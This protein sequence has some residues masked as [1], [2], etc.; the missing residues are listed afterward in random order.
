MTTSPLVQTLT[1]LVHFLKYS[2]DLFSQA[3]DINQF[4][5]IPSCSVYTYWMQ[6]VHCCTFVT[7]VSYGTTGV[8]CSPAHN[9]TRSLLWGDAQT[10]TNMNRRKKAFMFPW[11]DV[12]V[13]V[14]AFVCGRSHKWCWRDG[15]ESHFP[16]S[17]QTDDSQQRGFQQQTTE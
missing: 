9:D 16:S 17:H 4:L 11:M 8:R 13:K 6:F 14:C 3:R 7:L 1:R 12:P 15:P 2:P 10:P 5:N